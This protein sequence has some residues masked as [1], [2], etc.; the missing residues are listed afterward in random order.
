MTF[1]PD[2]I[3]A[4]PPLEPAFENILRSFICS[5]RR[6]F[7]DQSPED[8]ECSDLRGRGPHSRRTQGDMQRSIQDRRLEARSHSQ[9][10]VGH[11]HHAWL[12]ARVYVEVKTKVDAVTRA[13]GQPITFL[14]ADWVTLTVQVKMQHGM[15]IHDAKL[16][17]QS[18]YES[19]EERLHNGFFEDETLAHVV[20]LAD[21]HEQIAS[22]P[23][24]PFHLDVTLFLQ[25]KKKYMSTMVMTN[26]GQPLVTRPASPARS[27]AVCRLHVGYVHRFFLRN[28]CQATI[29]MHQRSLGSSS[30][31][32][33]HGQRIPDQT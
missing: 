25:T 20:S 14:T 4:S 5:R 26:V 15:S 31:G 21:D 23:E 7:S 9:S 32:P 11:V 24:P 18:Y 33:L 12:L 28:C 13:Y 6:H 30:M 19:F 2:Q 1:T 10:G 8:Q 3:A 16:P 27:P 17:A 22:K 29:S